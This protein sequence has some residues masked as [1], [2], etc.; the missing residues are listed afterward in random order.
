MGLEIQTTGAE[1]YG[2]HIKA[3][4]AGAPGAG[5]TLISSTFPYPIYASAEGGLMSVARR[6]VKFVNVQNTGQLKELRGLLSQD[7]G[8]REGMFGQPIQTL[9]VDT[10]DEIQRLFVRERLD[11]KR[12]ESFDQQD[13]GWL[14]EQMRSMLRGLRNLDMNVVFTCH[15]KEVTDQ[16]SGQVFIKPALQG[17]VGDEIAQYMDLAVLLRSEI[18]TKVVGTATE[19]YEQ[20]YLQTYKD[21]AHD[22]IK[23][24][25]GQLPPDVLVNFEDDYERIHKAIFGYMTEDWSRHEST[26]VQGLQE[27]LADTADKDPV[28]SLQE[29]ATARETPAEVEQPSV[30]EQDVQQPA[31]LAELAELKPFAEE[32]D[33]PSAT[34]EEETATVPS[35]EPK[36]SNEDGPWG[37]TDCGASIDNIDQKELSEI[38]ARKLLCS[39]CYRTHMNA[40]KK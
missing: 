6:K 35:P 32:P 30:E 8:V 24:R 11:A 2:Q 38:M 18:K 25:S 29:A 26:T 34:P 27:I 4:I 7:A 31:E 10:I 39:P 23:D 36:P 12:K 22:W 14:G 16:V 5:K 15:I 17:A 40:D 21:G 1:D 33:E 3:L 37:C 13:W 9:V 19:R 20:R 28:E